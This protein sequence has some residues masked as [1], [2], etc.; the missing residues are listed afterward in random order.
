MNEQDL[1]WQGK[2]GVEYTDRNVIS[3]A[4]RQ[5]LFRDVFERFGTP[6]SVCE[7][8][9]NRGHNLEAIKLCAPDAE[10][11][12]VEI[13]EYA[14]SQIPE[15]IEAINTSAFEYR[16]EEQYDLVL[17]CGFLIH[18]HPRNL[19][20]ICER[21]R[22]LSKKHVMLIEYYNEKSINPSYRGNS[23]QLFIRNFGDMFE[24]K[25]ASGKV[26]YFSGDPMHWWLF[27]VGQ[28]GIS[29]DT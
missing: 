25:I 19:S 28:G 20:E 18:I 9:A 7:L 11:T 22:S 2:F 27:D 17:T 1:F 4:A 14:Y 21:V 26:A 5:I 15:G 16:P 12:A 6:S 23:N 24:G 8:G 10:L 3:P 13:N 29:N